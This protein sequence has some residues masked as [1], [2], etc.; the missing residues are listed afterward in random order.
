MNKNDLV[1][2][3]WR[4]FPDFR[5]KDLEIVLDLLFERLKT[6]LKQGE[7]IEIRGFGRFLVREQ[8]ARRFK[9]PK[10]GKEQILPPRKRIIFKP[11]KD[12]KE[13]LNTPAKASLDLGTQ[14]F[15]LL[16]G[17]NNP[18]FRP[19]L[20]KRFNVRLGDGLSKTGEISNEAMKRGLLALKEIKGLLTQAETED[21]FAA[22]T[23]AFRRAKN[24]AQF[25]EKAKTELGI[26]IKVLSPE[27][28]AFFTAKGVLCLLQ[29]KAFPCL[30]IDVG[31]GSTE[32]VLC[33]DSKVHAWGSLSLGAVTLKE[34]CFPVDEIPTLK[35]I[36]T[37]KEVIDQSLSPIKNLEYAPKEAIATGGTASCLA[38]LDLRLE[39]YLPEKTH[40]HK[41]KVAKLRQLID[42]LS[43]L[44]P[45]ER[46]RL[47]GMEEGRE[48]IILP[49][50]LIFL[51]IAEALGLEYF[52]VSETGI[53]EGLLLH[54]YEKDSNISEN[55]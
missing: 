30:I 18:T 55:N 31:G 25:I 42:K 1:T 39:Y 45:Q 20:R 52:R 2:K 50:A 22:G 16:I 14:T 53:L 10:T 27:E 49:G 46:L 38:A 37:A 32:Y 6:A 41:L 54:L 21:V 11:G 43:K 12:L 17:K 47:K 15:R 33:N 9:N 29:K 24:A 34:K 35:E 5:R 23:E 8:K 19:I 48:D 36:E 44:S 51:G 28:E 40:G 3:L 26:E 13:R 7:R 4:K